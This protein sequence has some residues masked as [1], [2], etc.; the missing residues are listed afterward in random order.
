MTN[1]NETTIG[2][3]SAGEAPETAAGGV[4]V[5]SELSEEEKKRL[6]LE[7]AIEPL[8]PCHK[9]IKVTI[10]ET[11][12]HKVYE[13]QFGE[14][15]HNMVVPG[16][17]PGKVPRRLVERRYREEVRAGVKSK[18]LMRSLE[19]L[20][21]EYKLAP[22]APPKFDA[23]AIQVPD[24]GPL[25]FEI[26]V[27]V[28]PD[29]ELPDY[30]GIKITRPIHEFNEADVARQMRRFLEG[31]GT[32]VPCDKAV[33]R[34]DYVIVDVSFF[35]GDQLV[36][37]LEEQTITVQSV[38]RFRDGTAENFGGAMAGAKSGETRSVE[39]QVAD[40]APAPALRGKRLRGEFLV[41]DVKQLRLPELT[42]DFLD[43]LGYESEEQLRDGLYSVL[44]R[45]LEYEQRRVAR[46]Q[47]MAHLC[48]ATR[49]DV[50]RELVEREARRTMR[51]RLR[52][53]QQSGRSEQEIRA[54]ALQL[55]QNIMR[56]TQRDLREHF[57]LSRIAEVEGL[58][59]EDRDV[60]LYIEAMAR[61]TEES[62][63]RLRARLQKD[64]LLEDVEIQILEQLAVDRALEYAEYE[65]VP[66]ATDE[67]PEAAVDTATTPQPPDEPV[68]SGETAAE[69]APPAQEA[70]AAE[71]VPPTQAF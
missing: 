27:E 49:V 69:P 71:S 51:R 1:E 20:D 18:L 54:A 14:V 55:Q 57:I 48:A 15:V 40:E 9:R 61:Q 36:S 70:P 39:V 22:L 5:A 50:P 59:V 13:E 46:Q 3:E 56:E 26:E 7:V 34:G 28:Q 60:E 6:Q 12:V 43:S 65:N 8:G 10:P 23:E 63:R 53:L 67:E 2:E 4:A 32:L 24:A 17:R 47:L 31:Y 30:K 11:D 35:D 66:L 21:T 19:Q 33:E 37:R 41:K 52:D 45:R 16:Y 42:K 68:S 64:G 25:T 38:L 29:F 58:K 62:P 44:Q